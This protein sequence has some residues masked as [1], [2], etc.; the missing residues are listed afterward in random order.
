[1]CFGTI[2][3]PARASNPGTYNRLKLTST[4]VS[5]LKR[6]QDIPTYFEYLVL[7]SSSI[8]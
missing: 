4:R 8:N 2:Y 7:D 5:P 1:M 3:A 6:S